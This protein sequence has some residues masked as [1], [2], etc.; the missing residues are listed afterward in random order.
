MLQKWAAPRLL[1]ALIFLAVLTAIY[2]FFLRSPQDLELTSVQVIRE[3]DISRAD[4]YSSLSRSEELVAE[5]RF[6][7]STNLA[8][9]GRNWW[10]V[11][12]FARTYL[13]DGGALISRGFPL[14]FDELGD[15]S[16]Y[17]TA[18]Q[19][20]GRHKYHIYVG[21]ESVGQIGGPGKTWLPAYNLIAR[22]VDICFVLEPNLPFVG[23]WPPTNEVIIP[24]EVLARA[25]ERR[26]HQSSP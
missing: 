17:A 22:P 3:R 23:L 25:I 12:L 7:T 9:F 16:N 14:V 15:V 4:G 21:L 19:M 26:V 24:K 6:S 18:V 20:R 10:H 13:C 8:W 2:F 11:G 1:T 5:I